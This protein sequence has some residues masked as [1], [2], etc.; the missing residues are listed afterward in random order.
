[1]KETVT[2][3]DKEEEMGGVMSR[4]RELALNKRL[5]D[6]ENENSTL[7]NTVCFI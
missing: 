5:D 4:E 2:S 7:K 6:L 3:L 1:M